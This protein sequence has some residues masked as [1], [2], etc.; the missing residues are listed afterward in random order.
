MSEWMMGRGAAKTTLT[1]LAF[2]TQDMKRRGIKTLDD[3]L[4]SFGDKAD[5]VAECLLGLNIIAYD[6]SEDDERAR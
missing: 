5:D 6:W 1:W 3:W 2:I 4:R